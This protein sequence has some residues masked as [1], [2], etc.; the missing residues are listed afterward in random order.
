M[1]FDLPKNTPKL[2]IYNRCGYTDYIDFI[3]WNEFDTP[4]VYGIDRF[5]RSFVVIKFIIIETGKKIMQTF[6][7]RYTRGIT[8]MGCGHATGLLIDTTGGI[9]KDQIEFI[10]NIIN[11]NTVE[12]EDK[13]RPE[14]NTGFYFN[15]NINSKFTVSLFDE[16]KHIAATIIQNAWKLCRYDPIYKM[17]SKVQINNLKEIESEYNKEIL[18]N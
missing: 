7:Q 5:K 3:K 8:W 17:C 9:S 1:I 18:T 14:S 12:I 15:E 2:E 10:Q 13:H 4:I 11:G 16:K 6:F